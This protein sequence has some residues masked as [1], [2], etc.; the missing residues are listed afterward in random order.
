VSGSKTVT[1]PA[2]G[3]VEVSFTLDCKDPT[4]CGFKP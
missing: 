3:R 4:A 2:S 1:V